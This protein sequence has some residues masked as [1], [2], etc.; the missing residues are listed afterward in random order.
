MPFS[1]VIVVI[2]RGLFEAEIFVKILYIEPDGAYRGLIT[3]W[4]FIL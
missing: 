2:L 1:R 4:N 3:F